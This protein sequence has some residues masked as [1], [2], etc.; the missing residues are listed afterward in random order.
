L[1]LE[2]LASIT[3]CLPET[4][5]TADEIPEMVLPAKS[6][7]PSSLI[8][9]A[10]ISKSALLMLLTKMVLGQLPI[11]SYQRKMENMTLHLL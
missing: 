11:V 3:H 4:S 10:S 1:L 9:P 5:S 8:S 6:L 2:A 7:T